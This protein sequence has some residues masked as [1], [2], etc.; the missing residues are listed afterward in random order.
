MGTREKR[1]QGEKEKLS[2]FPKFC[3]FSSAR[4]GLVDL[5]SVDQL[6]EEL[7]HLHGTQI[8]CATVSERGKRR[9]LD[10]MAEK[11]KNGQWLVFFSWWTLV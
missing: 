11:E 2:I 8:Q 3:L 1:E 10:V 4:R 7:L 9:D 5:D 6:C